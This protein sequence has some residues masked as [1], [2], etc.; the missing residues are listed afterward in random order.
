MIPVLKLSKEEPVVMTILASKDDS[1][2]LDLLNDA[3]Y[4]KSLETIDG[5]PKEVFLVK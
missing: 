4:L 3:W 2:D 5:M 1:D